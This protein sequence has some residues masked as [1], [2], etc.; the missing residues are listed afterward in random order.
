MTD[1]PIIVAAVEYAA[2]GW[3]VIPVKGDKRPAVGAWRS[4]QTIAAK[5]GEVPDWF[6]RVKSAAGVGIVLGAVSGGLWVRDFDDAGA[7]TRWAAEHPE[8]AMSLPTVRTRRGWHVYGRWKGIRTAT[9]TD[10]ELRG[11]GAY[12]VA[13]PTRADTGTVYAWVVPLPTGDVPEV[14]PAAAGLAQGRKGKGCATERTERTERTETPERTE[15]TEDTEDTEDTEAIGERWP[16]ETERLILDVVTRT[17]P[18]GIGRRNLH[19]FKLARAL[20]AIPALA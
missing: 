5:A 17:L 9:M 7:Y 12:I 8:M 18:P 20:K 4:A 13:P 3:S 6:E 16:A 14:D 1:S 10:G 19:L 15:R 2:R 11:E